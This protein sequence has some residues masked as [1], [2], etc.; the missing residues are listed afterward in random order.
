MLFYSALGNGGLAV[1][2]PN[3]LVG[4]LI[5][6]SNM[7]VSLSLYPPYCGVNIIL[8]VLSWYQIDQ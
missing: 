8:L 1:T 5:V 4:H 7:S 3:I 6:Q 2:S